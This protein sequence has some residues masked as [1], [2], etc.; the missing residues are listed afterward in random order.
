MFLLSFIRNRGSIKDVERELGV[1]Y[2]TVRAALDGLIA[3][4]GLNQDAPADG[5][6]SDGAAA[7]PA[8]GAGDAAARPASEPNPEPASRPAPSPEQAKA[9]R[10]ILNL[11]AQ[12][13]ITADEAASQLKKL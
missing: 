13:R 8:S 3:S 5:A 6:A 1:S 4:L 7:I 12:H 2:P 10:D 11:L 9:R